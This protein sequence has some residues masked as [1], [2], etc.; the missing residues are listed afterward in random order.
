MSKLEKFLKPYIAPDKNG[1]NYFKI[2]DVESGI[3]GQKYII[4]DNKLSDFYNIYKKVVF[5]D[6][7]QTYLTEKQLED[8]KILIDLDFRY[9]TTI[10]DKQHTKEH[11]IDFIQMCLNGLCETFEISQETIS[12]YIF[13]KNN[14]NVLDDKT[15]DGIH[16][17]INVIANFATKLFFRNYLLENINDIWED[18]PLKNTWSDVIDEGVMKGDC[19]WQ[20]YGSRKP[21]NEQYKLTNIFE[22]HKTKDD[23]IMNEIEIKDIDFKQYFPYF[24]ARNTDNTHKLKIKKENVDKIEKLNPKKK[25]FKIKNRKQCNQIEDINCE[26]DLDNMINTLFNDNTTDYV[27]KEIHDYTMALPKEFWGPGSY[28]KWIRIGWTLKNT[29]EKL[30]IT[31]LKFSSQSEEFDFDHN[32]VLDYWNNFDV[33]TYS[34]E[35]LSYKSI[36]YWC[37]IYNPDEYNKIHKKTIDYYIY[38]AFKSGTECD[39]AES[40]YQMYKS[41]FVCTSIKD[42]YWY[43]FKN[44]R[45]CIIDSG[46]TLRTKISSEVYNQYAAKALQFQKD[47]SSKQNLL[48]DAQKNS[49]ISNNDETSDFKDFKK[50]LNNMFSVCKMLKKTNIKSNIMKE[51]KD[52]FYDENFQNKLDKNPYLLGCNNCV[53]DFKEKKHRPGKHDDY[54]SKSTNICYKPIDF[55]MKNNQKD[56]DDIKDFI[57][58]LFPNP[59]IENYMWEHLAACL[60]GL[61]HNQTFNIYTG[62]GANGKS[63]LVEL[64]TKVLGE[65]KGTVPISLITQKRTS[66][67]S[68]SSEIYN[69]IG[70]RYAVMQEPSKGDKINEG[71]MKE[72]TGGDPLQCRALFSNSITFNPQFK[73][74]VCTNTLLDVVSQDDGTWRRLRKVDFESKFTDK[75]FN[76]PKFP[77]HQY[78]HQFQ[79]DTKI[80]E[81]FKLWAP[82]LLSL[83]VQK[84]YETQGHV[85]DVPSVLAST[86]AYR[87]TQD[88]ILEFHNAMIVVNNDPSTGFPIKTRDLLTK[89]NDWYSKIYGRNKQPPGREVLNFFEKKYGKQPHST[90]WTNIKYKYDDDDEDDDF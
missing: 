52:L 50:E 88:V 76:D 36:I 23:I 59:E 43:Q 48:L 82:I 51:N 31:W 18:L 8:G 45:W 16:I 21:G 64:M 53:I 75:P 11:I 19:G 6:K 10:E 55:Y 71:I 89:F 7:K 2:G 81:K 90:G 70:V 1:V 25:L 49:V 3:F 41:Q 72:L 38:L 29:N 63:K 14:V 87:R 17:I 79:I 80:D 40:M 32:D 84:A 47:M 68:T 69:L 12:F 86:E 9:D 77:V 5:E 44:N 28:S 22:L 58:K 34:D 65:Y 24:C 27:L 37:K 60:I 83:L 39:L 61:N 33:Y 66:I 35:G 74:C 13:E 42:N 73:L 85:K 57:K 4:P 15:K 54:I 67:G 20:L 78:K 62:S 56:I 26:N 46:T 30:I